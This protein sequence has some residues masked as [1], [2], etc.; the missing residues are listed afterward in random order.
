MKEIGAET[1]PM[2]RANS[3]MQ[4]VTY[5]KANGRKTKPTVMVSILMSMVLS[6][7]ATGET[8]CKTA[9]A[10]SHGPMALATREAIKRE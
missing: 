3:G 4:M 9:P 2:D 1:R 6:M 8:I 5:T 7:R 10:L